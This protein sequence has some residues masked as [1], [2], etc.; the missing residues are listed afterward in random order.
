MRRQRSARPP[1]RASGRNATVGV[2][3]VI[4][5]VAGLGL[6]SANRLAQ[7]TTSAQRTTAVSDL[8]QDARYEVVSI[9]DRYRSQLLGSLPDTEPTGTDAF[10]A[11]DATLKALAVQPLAR[12][13]DLAALQAD[14]V[15]YVD[16]VRGVGQVI[17]RR[18][19]G[20]TAAE[21]EWRRRA[22]VAIAG[23]TADLG[24]LEEAGHLASQQHLRAASDEADLLNRLAPVVLGACVLLAFLL[25]GVSRRHRQGVE[26]LALTDALTRLPNRW[27]LTRQADLLSGGGTQAGGWLLLLDLDRFKEVN[28]SLGHHCGDE[29]LVQVADRLRTTASPAHFVTRLG[30]DEFAILGPTGAVTEGTTAALAVH[31]ALQAPFTVAGLQVQIGASIGVAASDGTGD[32]TALLRCADVAMYVAKQTGE[33][34][35][36]F[37]Q[38]HDVHT[39]DNLRLLSELRNGLADDELVVY[40]QP[41]VSLHDGRLVG[42]EALVRWQHPTRGLLAPGAFVPQIENT[43]LMDRVTAAVLERALNQVRAWSLQG[44]LIPVSVNIPTRSLLSAGFVD[45]VRSALLASSVDATMLTL[46]I[47]ESSAMNEPARA[48]Q[49]LHALRAS[50]VRVSIDDYG[51]GYASMAYLKDLPVDELKIDRSFVDTALQDNASRIL[52]TSIIDLAARLRLTVVAEGV[53]NQAT[54]DLLRDSGCQ[55]GQGYHY[56][57]P[58]PADA[59]AAWS[60]EHRSVR[61]AANPLEVRAVRA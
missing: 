43:M 59:L 6:H 2:L 16:A 35:V 22:D 1:S 26:Q 8:Y 19:P 29:L 32:L 38:D 4:A 13:E 46:E 5:A 11:L 28:D 53:E 12:P 15:V 25:A 48:V 56:A 37:S 49:V 47:T 57:R 33:P 45:Q 17:A 36:V 7:A 61:D 60:V 21:A 55:I 50:G 54:A 58:M 23:L 40:Y 51:T 52:V 41:K 39:A 10:R 30:G 18:D 31:A 14:L 27:A 20:T 9:D 34:Y 42:V 24:R 44:Q 3:L